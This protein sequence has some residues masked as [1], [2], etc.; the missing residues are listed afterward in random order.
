MNVKIFFFYAL[1]AIFLL[2]SCRSLIEDD[3]KTKCIYSSVFEG[4]MSIDLFEVKEDNT[5]RYYSVDF[6]NSQNTEG[7]WYYK[8]DTIVL[9]KYRDSTT[10]YGDLFI[11]YETVP[12]FRLNG[13]DTLSLKD[14]TYPNVR[15]RLRYHNPPKNVFFR[16]NRTKANMK[17]KKKQP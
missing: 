2:F 17:I 14:L 13:K 3:D 15:K 4:S 11:R 6:G 9:H 7:R 8:G 10:T 12:Y 5:F 1:I 16:V